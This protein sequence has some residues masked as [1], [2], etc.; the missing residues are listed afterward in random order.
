[1]EMIRKRNESIT[2]SKVKVGSTEVL[3]QNLI[4]W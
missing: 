2:I 4:Y 3:V 1:M